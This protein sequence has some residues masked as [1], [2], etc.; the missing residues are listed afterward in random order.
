VSFVWSV[1]VRTD[2]TQV[3]HVH[4]RNHTFRLGTAASFRPTDDHPSAIEALLGALAADVS[5][6][7]L[8]ICRRRRI[9]VYEL[10]FSANCALHNELVHLGV[11]GEEGSPAIEYIEATLYAQ[12]DVEE[13]AAQHAW[14]EALARSPIYATLKATTDLRLRLCLA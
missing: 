12:V 2:S 6:T 5:N 4:C 7:F 14:Q 3:A 10:E 11:V 1:R 13:L 8:T 9:T